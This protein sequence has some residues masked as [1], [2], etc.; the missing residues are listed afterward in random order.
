LFDGTDR[1]SSI[2][3]KKELP[4][5]TNNVMFAC[6]VFGSICPEILKPEE[7]G[8]ASALI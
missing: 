2:L 5:Q 8:D 7:A 6:E 3:L 4:F 1:Y